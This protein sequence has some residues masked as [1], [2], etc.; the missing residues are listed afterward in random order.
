[1]IEDIEKNECDYIRRIRNEFAHDVKITSF[2]SGKIP[3]LCKNLKSELP[4]GLEKKY[5]SRY[6]FQNAM[7]SM[8]MRLFYRDKY[9]IKEKRAP[10]TW[11]EAESIRWRRTD[12]ELPQ[13]GEPVIG[14]LVNPTQKS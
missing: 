13:S 5:T 3:N 6:I 11:V 2:E 1:M 7:L 8:S 14:I 12:E 4:D 10:K 9:V